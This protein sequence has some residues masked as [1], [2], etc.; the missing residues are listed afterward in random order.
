MCTGLDMAKEILIQESFTL[1]ETA[2]IGVRG[3]L[4]LI[5]KHR[6]ASTLCSRTTLD[7]LMLE[8]TPVLW[9]HVERSSLG[10]EL[11]PIQNGRHG[12]SSI[13]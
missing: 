1:M 8:V 3:A 10:I 13:R 5:F 12:N 9:L 7:A 6:V 4:R 11:N 2:V